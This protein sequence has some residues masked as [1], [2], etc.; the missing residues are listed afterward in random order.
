[1]EFTKSLSVAKHPVNEFAWMA[2][3]EYVTQLTNYKN[4]TT[5]LTDEENG[6]ISMKNATKVTHNL[7]RGQ[8]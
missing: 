3:Y 1:M 4:G 8:N 6:V 7:A 5:I 2:A